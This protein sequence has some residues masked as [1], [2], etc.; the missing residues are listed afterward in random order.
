MNIDFF[1]EY[2]IKNTSIDTIT[3]IIV[4][5]LDKDPHP[6][7]VEIHK[8]PTNQYYYYS[9]ELWLEDRDGN[10]AINVLLTP[11]QLFTDGWLYDNGYYWNHP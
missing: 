8:T 10:S 9:N 2:P 5:N 3:V 4:S 7:V 6:R 1:K 11:E